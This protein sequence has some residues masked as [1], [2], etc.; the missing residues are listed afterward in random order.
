[1][2]AALALTALVAIVA[3]A[4][5]LMWGMP[6]IF[7]GHHNDADSVAGADTYARSDIFSLSDG[8]HSGGDGGSGDGGAGSH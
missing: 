4:F 2:T 6:S 7:R 8:G 3:F 1:V 5:F